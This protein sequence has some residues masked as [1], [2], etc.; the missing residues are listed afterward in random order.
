MELDI[1][2]IWF[3]LAIGLFVIEIVISNY[4]AVCIGIGAVISGIIA[5]SGFGTDFQLIS[6]GVV[7]ILGIIILKPAFIKITGRKSYNNTK[8]FS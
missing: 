4:Y 7:A 2:H 5:F 8:K 3:V 6:F 1:W